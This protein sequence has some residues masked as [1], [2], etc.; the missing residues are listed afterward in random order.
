MREGNREKGVRRCVLPWFASNLLPRDSWNDSPS[1]SH[2]RQQAK[3][4]PRL[5]IFD[6]QKKSTSRV[7]LSLFLDLGGGRAGQV[8]I[9]TPAPPSPNQFLVAQN[10]IGSEGEVRYLSMKLMNV[11]E[12]S[13]NRSRRVRRG[14][15]STDAMLGEFSE[16][17]LRCCLGSSET[18]G[19]MVSIYFTLGAAHLT[20]QNVRP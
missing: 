10:N 7:C 2:W 16:E 19:Q 15:K 3:D 13:P 20:V 14:R 17:M 4:V 6:S 12:V 18:E 9:A 1:H 11:S 5:G 8:D